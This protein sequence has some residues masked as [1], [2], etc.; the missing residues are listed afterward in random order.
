MAGGTFM[1]DAEV[2]HVLGLLLIDGLRRIRCNQGIDPI[3]NRHL[4]GDRD[5]HACQEELIEAGYGA[6]AKL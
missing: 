6:Q 5:I 2:T 1:C 3:I 4:A